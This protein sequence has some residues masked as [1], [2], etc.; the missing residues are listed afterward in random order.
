MPSIEIM[1]KVAS[2][3][4][5]KKTWE[6]SSRIAGRYFIAE[7]VNPFTN[8]LCTYS[9]EQYAYDG[10]KVY[11]KIGD[12]VKIFVS[13]ENSN[14]YYLQDVVSAKV[15]PSLDKIIINTIA[16]YMWNRTP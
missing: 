16:S 2:I 6:N 14:D 4:Y 9:S 8:V 5:V 1:W 3:E 15:A 12:P 11:I 13:V 7:W 10:D